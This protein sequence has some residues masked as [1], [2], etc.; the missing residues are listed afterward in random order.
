MKK[1]LALSAILLSSTNVLAHDVS[2]FA[3][4]HEAY[5]GRVYI[6]S[7][8]KF[9]FI[10]NTFVTKTY[11]YSGRICVDLNHKGTKQ[12]CSSANKMD[13]IN[14]DAK[15]EKTI[16]YNLCVDDIWT[17]GRYR[18]FVHSETFGEGATKSDAL[19]WLN[20]D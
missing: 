7:D 2:S 4:H 5:A 20:V 15:S 12:V 11:N 1:L 17:S 10:N 16:R 18:I 9:R 3:G 14:V 13:T 19:G 8:H 6:C